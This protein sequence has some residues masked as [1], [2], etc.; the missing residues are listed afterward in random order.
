M[1]GVCAVA[2]SALLLPGLARAQDAEEEPVFFEEESAVSLDVSAEIKAG[3]RWSQE[4]RWALFT[5]F[6]PDFVPA[7]QE[8]VALAT[9]APGSSLEVNKA[10]LYVD[11]GLP[12]GISARVKIDFIDLYDRNPT[13]TDK[14]VDVDEAWVAFGERQQSLVPSEGTSFYALV[15]KAPKFERQAVRRIETYGLVSTA[16]NRFPD[17]QIQVGG[18]I[19]RNVYFFGQISDGN[20][21]FMRDPNA[22]AGDN[23]TK[24]PPNPELE[25]ASGFPIFYHAEVEDLQIDGDFEYGFGGGVRWLSYDQTRGIDVL[26]FYYQATL[27]E[28]TSL[29]GTLYQ[30]DLELLRGAGI[31]PNEIEGNDRT[32]W[33]F[34]LD[35]RAGGLG[36]FAQLVKE[37]SANLPRTG[38]EV[39]A[40]YRIA[41]GDLADPGALFPAIE[42]VVRY[43]RLTNDWTAPREFITQ[44]A[45]WDWQKWDFALRATIVPQL[46]LL[47][48]Y[49][50]NDMDEGS[51]IQGSILDPPVSVG[52]IRTID[53][54]EFLATLRL[55][56]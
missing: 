11:A 4:D 21:V 43:S 33:G 41:L 35:L 27:P 25:L 31:P 54:N 17:L 30:A 50:Y 13:S 15:G 2:V 3:Y 42:P 5:P 47:L 55:R 12:H 20:P 16:F 14:V 18:S 52:A 49:S 7:G 6:P 29:N 44:S 24:P 37:E 32:E 51:N 56:L 22:L 36:V 46:D 19:G 45:L 8:N 40:G 38:F 48:E 10:T 28:K 1:R 39:E 23:G 26:G 53:H 34:N 9:V